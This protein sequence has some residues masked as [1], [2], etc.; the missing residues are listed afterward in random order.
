MSNPCLTRKQATGILD[1]R[2]SRGSRY[3][4][5]NSEHMQRRIEVACGAIA[6]IAN[7]LKQRRS[8]PQAAELK[9]GRSDELCFQS[10]LS[11]WSK[12][13]N[14]PQRVTLVVIIS[15][16]R[17]LSALPRRSA[18][19]RRI[20]SFDPL[21]TK[22]WRSTPVLHLEQ[23]HGSAHDALRHFPRKGRRDRHVRLPARPVSF[24]LSLMSRDMENC[25]LGAQRRHP[26]SYTT[27]RDAAHHGV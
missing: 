1:C 27:T 23:M 17:L 2:G 5:S 9:Q 10:T 18:L 22:C 26:T 25:A 4:H 12:P 21:R 20:V 15:V 19:D 24:R 8:G 7:L 13:R 11:R 6:V 3:P 14:L 16:C